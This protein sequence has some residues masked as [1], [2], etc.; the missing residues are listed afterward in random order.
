[1]ATMWIS[2]LAERSGVPA[3]TLRF[4]EDAG[5]LTAGR[6]PAGY[7]MY[8]EDAVTRLAFIGSAKHLGLPL[9]EIWELLGVWE[10]GACADV[11]ADLR[12][13]IAA[14]LA[15]AEHR[16]AE[17]SAF[18]DSLHGVLRNL[19]TLPDRAVPCDAECG[20][21]D[22]PLPAGTPVDAPVDTPVDTHADQ[23]I[24]CSLTG[25]G[26][27]DRVAAW[28]TVTEGAAR[29][30]FPGG[31]RLALPAGR[32]A[33]VAELAAAEQRC[34]PFFDFRLRFAGEMI[35]LEVRAPADAAPLLTDLFS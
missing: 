2:Q 20:F 35:E 34:C 21:P 3:T 5:L 25:E 14:R 10:D 29:T 30:P 23:P 22:G 1:M 31:L 27:T 13:R 11:K 24:A 19:D 26:M 18:T 17:L 16:L 15:E 6:S 7:R 12:P 4:Y 33:A 8:G 9:A 28:R 32:A